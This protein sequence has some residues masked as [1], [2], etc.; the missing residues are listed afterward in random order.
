MPKLIKY[1]MVA[2][3]KSVQKIGCLDDKKWEWR[4]RYIG[5]QGE[6]YQLESAEKYPGQQYLYFTDHSRN[7]IKTGYGQI[8][9]DDDIVIITTRNSIYT[10]KILYEG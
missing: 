8:E 3:F 10:F 9:K 6:L 7:Y 4:E 1:F 2:E 5:F